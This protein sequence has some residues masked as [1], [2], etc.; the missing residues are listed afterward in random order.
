LTLLTPCALETVDRSL[1]K[2][3]GGEASQRGGA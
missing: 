1:A 3:G 2:P